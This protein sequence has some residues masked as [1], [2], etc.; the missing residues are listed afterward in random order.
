MKIYITFVIVIFFGCNSVEDKPIDK[1]KSILSQNTLADSIK[2][3]YYVYNHSCYAIFYDSLRKIDTL[4]PVIECRI[5][6]NDSSLVSKDSIFYSLSLFKPG[7]NYGYI[8]YASAD[9]LARYYGN[10]I[11]TSHQGIIDYRKNPDSVKYYFLL[12]ERKF[13]IYLKNYK[14][15]LDPWLK[16]EAIKRKIIPM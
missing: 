5:G 9:G 2:W 4:I 13:I 8:R 10:I 12:A 14:G 15:F 7:Y 1:S 16:D 6:I 11:P 3:H